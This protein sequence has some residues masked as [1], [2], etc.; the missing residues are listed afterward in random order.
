MIYV[1]G[2][3]N[4]GRIDANYQIDPYYFKGLM[5]EFRYWNR[6]LTNDEVKTLYDQ[7]TLDINENKIKLLKIYPNPTHEIIKINFETQVDYT[8]SICDQLGKMK[9]YTGN[10]KIIDL[11]SFPRGLYFLEVLTSD[12]KQYNNK[13]IKQ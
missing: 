2:V 10:P 7:E 13:L 4:I 6:G 9:N 11:R 8:V 5:D 3:G 1:S 12:G